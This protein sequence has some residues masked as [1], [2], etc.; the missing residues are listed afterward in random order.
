MIKALKNLDD[1]NQQNHQKETQDQDNQDWFFA[2]QNQW[3]LS[4]KSKAIIPGSDSWFENPIQVLRAIQKI[5]KKNKVD[6]TQVK[7]QLSKDKKL[8]QQYYDLRE[9][10]YRNDSGYRNYS[11][12]ENDFDRNGRIFLGL[13]NG[14]VVAGARLVVSSD[15]DYL[16]HENT[17]KNFTYNQICK[18][19]GINLD[20]VI[21]SEISALV[22]DRSFRKNLLG[23]LFT[24]VVEHCHQ[25]NIKYI[26]GVSNK[27]CN[28]DYKMVFAK[29]G[30]KC[31]ISNEIV[32]PKK[33][34]FNNIDSYPIVAIM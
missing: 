29:L 28:R 12:A 33:S 4:S 21:Y 16:P 2:L 1:S 34:E 18:N 20:G 13:Y 32:A 26:F 8:L 5:S 15:V 22:I 3:F 9:S 6:V 27:Q 30:I 24:S 7:I 25:E 14:S 23:I 19:L 11:G 17:E 10:L 31:V